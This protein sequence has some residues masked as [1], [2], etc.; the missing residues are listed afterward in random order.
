V[1]V[2]AGVAE[3]IP[4]EVH[5]AAL[6]GQRSRR[7]IAALS[8]LWASETTSCTPAYPVV[9][10]KRRSFFNDGVE[11]MALDLVDATVIRPGV[12]ILTYQS[13]R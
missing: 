5:T 10:G 8:P 11:R 7:A 2:L 9:L 3:A 12:A 13:R 6:P 4:E 1:L